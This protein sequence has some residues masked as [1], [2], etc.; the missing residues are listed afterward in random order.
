MARPI[1]ENRE[2][3]EQEEEVIKVFSARGKIEHHKMPRRY[4]IDY[5]L[6]RAGHLYGWAEVKVR[7][8]VEKYESFIIGASKVLSGR[9]LAEVFGGR[10]L[11]IVRRTND[12]MV[13][14]A[15]AE[16][17]FHVGIGGR[18]DR[19]DDQD[20]EP[21]AHYRWGGMTRVDILS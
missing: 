3:M 11:I 6:S 19:N 8:G 21:V 14:D 13:L 16:R 20:V 15:T 9:R 1:Y 12:I 5:M 10:F 18:Y 2:T 7:P 4:E 17:P